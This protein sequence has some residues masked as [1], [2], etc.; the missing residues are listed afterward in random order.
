MEKLRPFEVTC[1][2]GYLRGNNIIIINNSK[3]SL[4]LKDK[5]VGSGKPIQS[6]PQKIDPKKAGQYIF[7][8]TSGT[9]TGTGGVI[10]MNFEG[11]NKK[12]VVMFENPWSSWN[13]SQVC[14]STLS[15]S[16]SSWYEDF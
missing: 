9:A 8:K 11:S 5:Y 4:N 14:I 15:R 2:L 6:G 1:N 16:A 12:L 10:I 3:N 7:T 13:F